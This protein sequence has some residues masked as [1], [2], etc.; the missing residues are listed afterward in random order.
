[1]LNSVLL[2]KVRERPNSSEAISLKTIL[3]IR[4]NLSWRHNVA[5]A[6]DLEPGGQYKDED[7]QH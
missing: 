3:M 1:M 6:P 5:P 4:D 7:C 2:I